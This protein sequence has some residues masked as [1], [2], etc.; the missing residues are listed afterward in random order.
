MLA[1]VQERTREIGVRLAIG[2]RRLD[3]FLQ[4]MVQTIL[5]TSLGGV[6][7]IILGYAVLGAIGRYLS[8][9]LA[10]SLQMIYAAL[11][12]SVGVGLVFGIM[13]AVRASNLNPVNALRND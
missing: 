2:A 4:F 11:L 9:N 8:M 12:V 3:I 13:P 5:I 7:G 1:S 10:A 6:I